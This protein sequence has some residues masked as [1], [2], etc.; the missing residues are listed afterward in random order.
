MRPLFLLFA[1]CIFLF[2]SQS[3]LQKV[4]LQLMWQDQFQFAGY[5]IAKERGFYEEAG[6]D[7]EI[8]KFSYG[9]N[10]LDEVSS[11]RAT[12]GVANSS[13]IKVD[14]SAQTF[15]LLAAIF[16]SSPRVLISLKSSN[17]NNIED[18]S[19]KSIMQT[20]DFVDSALMTAVLHSNSLNEKNVDFV[21][22]TYDIRELIN[23]KVDVYTGYIS[24]EPYVLEE[25]GIEYNLL[26]AQDQGLDFYSDILF[27]TQEYIFKNTENV[28]KFKDASLRGWVYAFENIDETVELILNKYNTQNKSREALIFEAQ[29]L[30][31]LAYFNTTE[32]GKIEKK[33]LQR[34]YD[35]YKI[36][37]I[38]KENL[39]I[40]GLI[41]NC[42]RV[43]F[44]KEEKEYIKKHPIVSYCTQPD[45]LPYSA[46]KDSQFIGIGKGILDLVTRSSGIEFKLLETKTWDESL[47]K[48]M[49]GECDVLPLAAWSPSREK[50]FNFTDSY[51]SEPLVITTTKEKP[52]ILDIGSVLGEKFSVV[53]GNS[54]FENLLKK[55]PSLNVVKVDSIK[56]GL[57]GVQRGDYFGHIDI[58]MSTAYAMQ[59]ASMVDMKIAGQFDDNI[60]VRLAVKKDDEVLFSIFKKIAKN[61]KHEDV[62]A[63]LNRWISV[64]YTT[65]FDIWYYKEIAA[66]VAL[67]L[68][69]LLYREYFLKKKNRELEV[70]QS[71]LLELN[72]TLELRVSQATEE[73]EKAQDI[74]N[75][76]SWILDVQSGELRWSKQTYK[77]FGIEA[78]SRE[79]LYQMFRSRI[80][81]DD[82]EEVESLY[83]RS[84]YEKEPYDITHKLLMDDGS[85]KYVHEVCETTFDSEGRAI[86]S[87][88]TVQDVTSKIAVEQEL[89][90]KDAY[91]LHQSRLAQMGEMLSMIAHQW[92]QPL[93]A[94]SATQITIKT[95]MELEKYDLSDKT[96]R[97]AFITFVDERLDKISLYVQSL[98]KTIR[99][100]SDYYKPNKRAEFINIDEVILRSFELLKDSMNAV[101]IEV[102]FDLNS[103]TELDIH[104]NE[105]MQVILNIVSNAKEQ[106]LIKEVK[107]PRVHI[108]TCEDSSF[109]F[110]EIEDNAGGVDDEIIENIFDPY[111]S[112]KLEKNGTGLGLYMS[113]MII[114]EYHNGNL[115]VH[116]TRDGA[117]FTIRIKK[118]YEE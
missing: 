53:R 70:L 6:L 91:L 96:Q 26:C 30:K 112:T 110:I 88:G 21:E 82:I 38:A 85:I 77:I 18:L 63:V 31:K 71:E 103:I 43:N 59:K 65:G 14:S 107:E 58:M 80:H 3:N 23:K 33:K 94:I 84:I 99:D 83:A 19:G 101:E 55:Y 27:T 11:R 89:K 76:G 113:R 114:N 40:S 105:F 73:L 56:E 8:K 36:L 39:D 10:T 92:K 24:N 111:F 106:L 22:H 4:S 12:F 7:V 2:A 81:P 78:H 32:L 42:N 62:Q 46:I 5:Y 115:S 104:T 13:I 28:E 1:S 35:I 49:N 75:I 117:V 9:I 37:G 97:A 20:S 60:E 44:T 41:F 45:A 108:R 16:Q 34:V 90:K 50:Y 51:Y 15:S 67:F 100:F 68:L 48:A 93:S 52:Y 87:H 47:K 102:E 74:A 118:E 69:F 17:I 116:N 86:I 29:A 61:L 66:V 95:T 72:S 64:N 109:I 54:F 79:N 98:A 25:K 57:D